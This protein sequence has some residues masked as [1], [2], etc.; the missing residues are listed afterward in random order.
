M[1]LSC[2][3][4]KRKTKYLEILI[5]GE[6]NSSI[7]V[8]TLPLFSVVVLFLF[9]K[10]GDSIYGGGL[11]SLGELLSLPESLPCIQELYMLLNLC[12]SPVNLAF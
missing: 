12:F 7:C 6:G 10:S 3:R 1:S 5:N 11:C 2:S 9:F 8:T 4:K